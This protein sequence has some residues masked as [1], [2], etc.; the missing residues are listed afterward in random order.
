MSHELLSETQFPQRNLLASLALNL[1]NKEMLKIICKLLERTE[2]E[3]QQRLN[4]SV[5]HPQS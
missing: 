2:K 5:I 4:S 1:T 3:K